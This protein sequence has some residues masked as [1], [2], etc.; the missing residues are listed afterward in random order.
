MEKE[1]KKQKNTLNKHLY[2]LRYFY[3]LDI[4]SILLPLGYILVN[5]HPAFAGFFIIGQIVTLGLVN[6][7][8]KL[9]VSHEDMSLNTLSVHPVKVVSSHAL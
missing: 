9:P 8:Q 3:S 7:F 6:L 4:F 1:E 5:S 2:D